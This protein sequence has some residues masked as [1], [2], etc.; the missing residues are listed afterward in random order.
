MM[1]ARRTA[2]QP[3]AMGDASAILLATYAAIATGGV[4]ADSTA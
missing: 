1:E 3:I 2:C 4:I